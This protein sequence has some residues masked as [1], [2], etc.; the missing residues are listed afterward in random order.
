MSLRVPT[1]LVGS[2]VEPVTAGELDKAKRQLEASMVH[3]LTTNS[4]IASRIGYDV[5]VLGAIRPLEDRLAAIQAVDA[6][7]VQRV[8]QTYLID[9]GRNIVHVVPPPDSLETQGGDS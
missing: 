7:D 6:A 2:T 9:E 3:Q 4:A 5:T 1:W 8:A